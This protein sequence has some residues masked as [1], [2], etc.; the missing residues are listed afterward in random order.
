MANRAGSLR[1]TIQEGVRKVRRRLSPLS[2]YDHTIPPEILDDEFYAVIQTLARTA[3][4]S[5]ALEIG[6]SNGAGSTRAFVEGLH[7]NPERPLL[8]CLEVSRQRFKELV[9]RYGQDA[10]VRCYNLTSVSLERFPSE[11]AVV[12]FYNSHQSKLSRI[13]LREVLRWWRQD[14]SYV[15]RLG[16]ARDGIRVIKDEN[17][18]D[19]FGMVLIDGSEFTGSAELEDVYG[20]DY[21][22]LDDIGTYKNFGNYERL[23]AD[24]AY[25]LRGSNETLRNGYA[26]FERKDR[27]G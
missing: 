14:I 26:V 6:S 20:A 12:D 16:E 17:H 2:D 9:L 7:E 25:S 3:S 15:G 27:P 5:T 19:R 23:L 24:P 4:I 8:F 11:A 21:I 13:P 10:Q 22:L 1:S 18:V